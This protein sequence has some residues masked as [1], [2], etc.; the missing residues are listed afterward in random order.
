MW[1]WLGVAAAMLMAAPAS[2]A[3][4]FIDFFGVGEVTY[5]ESDSLGGGLIT[6]PAVGTPVAVKGR[7]TFSDGSDPAGDIAIPDD[8]TGDIFF[9][10]VRP[11]VPYKHRFSFSVTG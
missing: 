10:L 8:Y 1:K 3:I 11:S 6:G 7:L 9:S 5:S 2:A 4:T